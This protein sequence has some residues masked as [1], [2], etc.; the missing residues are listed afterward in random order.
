MFCY[1]MSGAHQNVVGDLAKRQ[2]QVDDIILRAAA[3]RK[4]ADVNNSAGRDLS[5]RKWLQIII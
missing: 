5:G 1:L 3:F 2:S 4:V